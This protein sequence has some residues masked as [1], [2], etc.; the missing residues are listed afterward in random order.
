[1]PS[2]WSSNSLLISTESA[3]DLR[4][5]ENIVFVVSANGTVTATVNNFRVTCA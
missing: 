2:R 1:V 3:A 4:V 5:H